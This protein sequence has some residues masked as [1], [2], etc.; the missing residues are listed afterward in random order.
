MKGILDKKCWS[1]EPE[2]RAQNT[3]TRGK[4]AKQ[5]HILVNTRKVWKDHVQKI[6]T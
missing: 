2:T 1:T 3:A 5:I 6:G 4:G